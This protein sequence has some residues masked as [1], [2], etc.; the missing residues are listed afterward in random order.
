LD[1]DNQ[2]VVVP[3]DY[4][5]LQQLDP[6]K[7]EYYLVHPKLFNVLEVRFWNAKECDENYFFDSWMALLEGGLIYRLSAFD[8][9]MS[10]SGIIPESGPG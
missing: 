9:G 3:F 7:M 10:F 2:D 6:V 8:T 5:L 4:P 1:T